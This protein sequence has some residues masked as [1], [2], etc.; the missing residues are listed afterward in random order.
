MWWKGGTPRRINTAWVYGVLKFSIYL[1]NHLLQPVI[2]LII[3]SNIYYKPYTY[4]KFSQS[5]RTKKSLTDLSIRISQPKN[6]IGGRPPINKR[7]THIV[8]LFIVDL[9]IMKKF[10]FIVLLVG[11]GYDNI[12][13]W[14]I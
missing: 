3:S 11:V 14:T 9:A 5:K 7:G 6:Q 12:I 10:L 2:I 13:E 1:C 8:M 4:H